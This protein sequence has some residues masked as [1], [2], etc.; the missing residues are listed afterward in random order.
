MIPGWIEL[1]NRVVD[2]RWKDGDPWNK[3]WMNVPTGEQQCPDCW[4]KT[5]VRDNMG[6]HVCPELTDGHGSKFTIGS[7][8]YV[9]AAGRIRKGE[10]TRYKKDTR[11]LTVVTVDKEGYEKKHVINDLGKVLVMK[12]DQIWG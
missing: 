10:V 3:R 4:F 8:I 11:M 2:P 9:Y 6:V 1:V 7:E 5:D 12:N